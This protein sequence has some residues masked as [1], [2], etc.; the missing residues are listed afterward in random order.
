MRITG[1][2]EE[3]AGEVARP[4]YEAARLRYGKLPDPLTIMAYNPHVLSAHV[5]Y[6]EKFNKSGLVD[7][8]L[9][10]IAQI[11]AATMIGCPW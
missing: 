5:K 11:K 9:I 4:L 6:D 3:Q 1:L 7:K 10:E 2:S 8:R